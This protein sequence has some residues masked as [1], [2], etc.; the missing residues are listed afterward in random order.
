MSEDQVHDVLEGRPAPR[1]V[2]GPALVSPLGDWGW[3][4]AGIVSGDVLVPG[5]DARAHI[6]YWVKADRDGPMVRRLLTFTTDRR[7]SARRTVFELLYELSFQKPH[8][9]LAADAAESALDDED[10]QVRRTAAKLLVDTAEP[11]RAL[12]ALNASTDPVVRIAFVDA[13]PW[14]RV[15]RH[16]AIL[17]SLRSDPVPAVRLLANVAAFSRDDPA[18]R[19]ALD[20]AIRVD[21]ESCAGVLNAPGSPLSLTAGE[22]WARTL[23]GLDREQDCY[24]WAQRLANRV[25]SPQVK[26]EGVRIA[27]AAMREWR[28]APGRV[29]PILTG[30]LQDDIP[31]VRSAALHAVAASL[32]ASRLAADELAAVLDEPELGAVAATALGSV[33]DQRAVPRLVRLMLSGGEE[34]RLAE[35]FRAV[36]RAGADPRAPVAAAR[37]ILAALP[38]S[39]EPGLP[40][41][42]L[43]AFGPAAAAAVPE[44]VA[45]LEGA[46]NDTPDCAIY[47]LGRIGPAAAAAAASLRQYPLQ[48]ATLALLRVTSDRAVAE[49]Y[50]DGRPEE[51]RRGRVAAALLS[52]LAEHGGLTTRQHKQLRSLFRAPGFG[53]LESAGALWLHEGPAVAAELLEVLPQY[54]SDDLYGPK[55]L[56]VLAAMGSHA[57]P[58][59]DRLDRF[60]ASRHR[61]GMSIG[62]DDA[63]MRADEYCS[64][65]PSP[66]AR[67]SPNKS[68][69]RHGLRPRRALVHPFLPPIVRVSSWRAVTRC[70]AEARRSPH[71]FVPMTGRPIKPAGHQSVGWFDG[72]TEGVDVA[73]GPLGE[74]PRGSA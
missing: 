15:A 18:A 57:R 36:A 19:P 25:E 58:V 55:A 17:E 74:G 11:E 67:R 34:P 51:L 72:S 65:P 44:L 23:T 31:E 59:L 22:R 37:Q 28:V 35:A 16:Q 8:W 56:R 5:S 33:G 13:I 50:L 52:W 49:Q 14:H 62:D 41:R 54:L 10:P 40:M 26:D 66:P 70:D 68:V 1:R 64:L 2:K 12:A 20:A 42:V 39:C 69:R 30:L 21:L 45:R 38:D 32:T 53:Q 29:T 3:L 46:E 63:E 6:F 48:G 27:L 61:A 60:V 47:V 4:E 7:L 71:T 9:P 43:A 73:C 24:A